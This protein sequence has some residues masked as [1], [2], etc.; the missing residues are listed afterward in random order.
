MER[1]ISPWN[2]ALQRM[3]NQK[4]APNLKKMQSESQF[5]HRDN[6]AF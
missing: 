3:R 2:P 6:S 5:R 4:S 1:T